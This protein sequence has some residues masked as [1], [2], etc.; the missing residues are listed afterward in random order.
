LTRILQ[1]DVLTDFVGAETGGF[2]HGSIIERSEGENRDDPADREIEV[3]VDTV[4]AFSEPLSNR[5]G[6]DESRRGVGS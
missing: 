3:N 2:P 5:R 6:T 1:E 4:A